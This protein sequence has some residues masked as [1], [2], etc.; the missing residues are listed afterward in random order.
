MSSLLTSFPP[1]FIAEE[2]VPILDIILTLETNVAGIL[3]NFGKCLL[4]AQPQ[5][6]QIKEVWK[7]IWPLIKKIFSRDDYLSCCQV[8]AEF[9]IK[10][11]DV[12]R[13]ISIE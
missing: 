1:S 7:A 9:M 12:S 13:L 8:W 10:H 3:I 11:F 6:H 2:C 5:E 4:I